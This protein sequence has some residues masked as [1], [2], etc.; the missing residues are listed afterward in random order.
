MDRDI[1]ASRWTDRMAAMFEVYFDDS[2]THPASKIAVAACYV[3]TRRGWKEFAAEWDRAR[4]EEHFDVFHMAE[5]VALP[6]NS[7]E[8]FCHWDRSKKEHVYARLAKIINQ[9]K[10]IG[11]AVAV[12]KEAYDKTSETFRSRWGREHYTFAAR[13]CLSK[14]AE[15]RTGS[16]ITD[17]FQYIF[18]WEMKGS[19]K[20][21]EIS[22][23]WDSIDPLA[24]SQL[25]T[26]EG[27][28]SFQHKKNVKPLQAADVLAWQMYS[29]M[30]KI[31]NSEQDRVEL[32]HPGF[33]LL[34]EDQ[35]MELA[36]FTPKQMEK[37]ARQY[38]RLEADGFRVAL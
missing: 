23:I 38:E 20:R 35:E 16:Q 32:A 7:H 36:F 4:W 30:G 10:R 25:G 28:L 29:H 5:F 17:G 27:G 11:V 2:G 22:S 6:E 18:D 15:W 9:N 34:R 1:E 31:A 33:R 26:D 24:S 12:P 19:G 14:I 3:S 8:P 21:I 37:F 13:M